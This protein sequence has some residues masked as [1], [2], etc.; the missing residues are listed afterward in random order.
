MCNTLGKDTLTKYTNS[1]RAGDPQKSQKDGFVTSSKFTHL[2][3]LYVYI[4][5]K[6]TV[7]LLTID[8]S[9]VEKPACIFDIF[10]HCCL[11]SLYLFN[12]RCLPASLLLLVASKIGCHGYSIS[13]FTDLDFT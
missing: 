10:F 6:P 13:V 12:Y 4:T 8:L 9:R 5:L 2:K 3:N 11:Y 7:I 1:L